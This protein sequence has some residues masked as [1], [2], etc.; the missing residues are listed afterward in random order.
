LK[1]EEETGVFSKDSQIFSAAPAKRRLSTKEAGKRQNFLFTKP[2]KHG[3]L[4]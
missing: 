3:T 4:I 1:W 2:G